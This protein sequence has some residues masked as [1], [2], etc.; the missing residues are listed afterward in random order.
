MFLLFLL[1]LGYT[2]K[3]LACSC[4]GSNEYTNMERDIEWYNRHDLVFTAKVD[5][6]VRYPYGNSEGWEFQK[7]HLTV[8]TAYKGNI[9]EHIII[10]PP[11]QLTS[12]S[13]AFGQEDIGITFIFY[14]YFLS[15]SSI[16][17]HYC[18]GSGRFYTRAEIDTITGNTWRLQLLKQ[19]YDLL[20]AVH[21]SRNGNVITRYSNGK[22]T[23]TGRFRE[24]LPVGVWTYFNYYGKVMEQG[25]YKDGKKHGWWVEYSYLSNIR[26]GSRQLVFTHRYLMKGNYVNGRKEGRWLGVGSN[27]GKK[28]FFYVNGELKE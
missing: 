2:V 5:S 21:K 11:D 6:I 25:H 4:T 17:T 9:P 15:D 1:F 13:F 24:G 19:E 26:K 28:Q 7:V 22:L 16:Y 10:D 3:A 23:G 8:L 20:Q 14:G 12:C 18:E 27:G